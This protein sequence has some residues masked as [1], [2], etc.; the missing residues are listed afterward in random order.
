MQS[1]RQKHLWPMGEAAPS[2][3][4]ALPQQK[5]L[6][7]QR[8]NMP[9]EA[10]VPWAAAGAAHWQKLVVVVGGAVVDVLMR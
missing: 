6:Q 7:Q 9:L 8:H 5:Q 4:A 10:Q 3:A 2:Q 1:Q